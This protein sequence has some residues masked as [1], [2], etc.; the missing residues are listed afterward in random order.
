MRTRRGWT[1]VALLTAFMAI[2]AADKA[3]FGLAAAPIMRDFHLTHTA[4]GAI[5]SSFFLLFS[6]AALVAGPLSDRVHGAWLVLGMAL[7]WTIAQGAALFAA[8][9][10]MLVALRVLLGAGEG[11]ALATALHVAFGG[12]S[13]RD[14]PRITG[15]L[16]AGVP[17]GTGLAAIGC[18]WVMV[19]FGWRAAFA[20]LGLAS[21]LWLCIW[22]PVAPRSASAA[23]EAERPAEPRGR[24][25]FNPTMFGVAISTFALY[26]VNGIALIWYPAFLERAYGLSASTTGTILA[27][28]WPIQIAAYLGGVFL[29]ERL[30]RRH[31]RLGRDVLRTIAVTALA[32][33]TIS[34]LALAVSAPPAFAVAVIF[35]SL[36]AAAVAFTVTGPIV[37]E[38][39]SD[40]RRG[41]AFGGL[42]ALFS[43]AGL[44]GPFAFGVIIDAAGSAVAGYREAFLALGVV[45]LCATVVAAP[46]IRPERDRVTA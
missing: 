39:T 23:G 26:M 20:L 22:L 32:A 18:T 42:V 1:V 12:L 13:V 45:M 43:L 44:I 3:V 4:F 24:G 6:I 27:I 37:G 29:T 2:N 33:A 5:G 36:V 11:P 28:G 17:L 19:H 14:R 16:L 7:I 46:L 38:V 41:T 40:R 25:I 30:Q 15:I 9:V 31:E 35:S 21:F 34:V 10:P 8:S